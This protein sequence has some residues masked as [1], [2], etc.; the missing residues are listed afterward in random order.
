MGPLLQAPE[1]NPHATLVTFFMNAVVEMT[2][3]ETEG[4]DAHARDA[5]AREQIEK[6]LNLWPFP[7]TP[8]SSPYDSQAML[9]G[10]AKPIVCDVDKYFDRYVRLSTRSSKEADDLRYM[11]RFRFAEFPQHLGMKMKEHHTIIDKW[12]MRLKLRPGQP[13]AKEEF[14]LLFS[15]GHEGTERYVEWKK[16]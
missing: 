12:P 5:H 1:H 4:R 11:K 6:V 13:G 14:G 3:A 10:A 15:T 8:P 16:L 9:M 2:T 7:I